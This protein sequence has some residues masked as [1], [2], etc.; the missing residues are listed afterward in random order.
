MSRIGTTDFDAQM[1]GLKL[2]KGNEN[3]R[4]VYEK[5]FY[6]ILI[7]CMLFGLLSSQKVLYSTVHV[8]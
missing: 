5:P 2:W 8:I 4:P 6:E 1:S 3:L 7:G